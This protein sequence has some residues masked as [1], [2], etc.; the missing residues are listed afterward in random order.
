MKIL[1]I[2]VFY[3]FFLSNLSATIIDNI[4]V[5]G[6]KRISKET[7]IVIGD[8]KIGTEFN[9]DVL[10]QTIKK[11]YDSNFF[12][13]LDIY[14][15]NKKLIINVKENPI[16]NS[17]K[18]TGIKNKSLIE[19]LTTQ[20]NLKERTSF[21]EIRLKSDLDLLNNILKTSG[22]YFSKVEASKINNDE[23]NSVELIF[24]IELND[25]S[26]IKKI[27]FLGNKKIKENKLLS[28]IA[29]E[30]HKFWK[31]LSNNVYLNQSIVDLDVRLLKNFYKNLGF[32]NANI[33]SAFAEYD[34]NG[35]FELI[36]TIE[37]GEYYFFDNLNLTLPKD[38]NIKDFREI[39]EI[40]NSMKGERY[41]LEKLQSVLNKIEKIASERLYDFIDVGVEEKISKNNNIDLTF[42]INDS[43]KYYIERVNILGNFQTAESAIRNKFILDEG[44]P[45]NKLLLNKTIDNIKSL[46][47]FK[48]VTTNVKDG[49]NENLKIIDLTVEEQPT[50][51]ITL[52]A[53]AGTNGVTIA[54]GIN[55]KN[56]LGQAI[57]LNTN[58]EISEETLK[59]YIRFIKPNFAYTDNSLSSSLES[60]TSDLL[61]VSGYKVKKTGFSIGTSFEQYENLTYSPE[62]SFTFEDLETI[63]SASSSIKKQEGKYE[64][65]YFNYSFAY[66]KTNSRFEPTSGSKTFFYQELPF[67]SKNNEI[68]NT[69]SYTKYKSLNMSDDMIAKASIYF[70]TINN[71]SDSDVRI[72]KRAFI[73]YNR[74]RGFEKGKVGPIDNSDYIGGNYVY[75]A[76]LSTTLPQILTTVEN[77]DFSYFIDIANVWGVD[78][79]SSLKKS[80]KIRSSTGLGLDILTPIGP[81]SLSYSIPI[82]KSS[83]DK[84]EN[85]RFNIGT[86][87]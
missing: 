50:G 30:E 52:A 73:P 23:L 32:Y 4:E 48:N 10:N 72:S 35:F 39:N 37:A 55:E 56:F 68:L 63:S 49:S 16:I 27:K 13:D 7:I 21:S 5:N 19:S 9:D 54:G 20:I 74:L 64:D 24:D 25:K 33:N 36:F 40:L 76:N 42:K 59:G 60:S 77:L 71:F 81:L 82:S 45:L 87:F 65:L 66:D 34:K 58:I 53:G 3:L 6:N 38:Y 11:L 70:K 1:L 15:L 51:E 80:N 2:I 69:F 85:F 28:V 44:D 18:F 41:S 8:I 31:F 75:A 26:K 86:N 67:V 57:N 78:Y 46:R 29:S 47:I 17:I 62:L 43:D 12:F 61:S 79:D 83:T 22:Y 14:I 84:T